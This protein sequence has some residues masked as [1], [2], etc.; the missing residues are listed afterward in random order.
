[1]P[2]SVATAKEISRLCDEPSWLLEARVQASDLFDTLPVETSSLYTRQTDL[3][4]TNLIDFDPLGVISEH[5]NEA[6]SQSTRTASGNYIT[7]LGARVIEQHLS[8]ELINKGVFFGDLYSSLEQ[9][10]NLIKSV[11]A[12]KVIAPDDDK[13]AAYNQAFYNSALV[14]HVPRGVVVDEPFRIRHF[15]G[16]S[17]AAVVSRIFVIAEQE[18]QV[19]ILL[20]EYS[21]SS[22]PI[23]NS[24]YSNSVELHAG[25]GARIWFQELQNAD[26]KTIVLTNKRCRCRR[27]SH[28]SWTMGYMG[29]A[30]TKSRVDSD[31]LGE[32]SSSEEVEVVFGT[33]EQKFDLNSNVT[34]IAPHTKSEIISRGVLRDTAKTIFKGML[35]IGKDARGADS[36][37]AEH[38][39]LLNPQARADSIPALEIATNEVKAAHSAS[40][41]QIE[42]E[43]IFY[44]MSRGIPE[45]E[46]KKLIIL[47]FLEPAVQRIPVEEVKA[48]LIDLVET[49]W[50]GIANSTLEENTRTK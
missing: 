46:A 20:E 24:L 45:N 35:R 9:Q 50:T 43:P 25:D 32:G 1:M 3:R 31:L 18:S 37:L 49:K 21:K 28:V 10:P 16:D 40:V 44:L 14:L 48:I 29:G 5:L 41:A 39:M 22:T 23:S 19:T 15:I 34:H 7:S 33:G 38:A 12:D 42:E 47:A 17:A 36:F 30:Y 4:G 6:E 27:D 8:Q 13:F 26:E 11:L 2:V